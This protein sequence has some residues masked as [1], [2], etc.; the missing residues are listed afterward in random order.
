MTNLKTNT[1]LQRP[2]ILTMCADTVELEASVEELLT[3]DIF[4]GLVGQDANFVKNEDATRQ[5]NPQKMRRDISSKA[6]NVM[7]VLVKGDATTF[8]Q[9][10][11]R[12]YTLAV[13]D[14]ITLQFVC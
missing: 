13:E 2:S 14:I 3:L 8:D 7:T 10:F 1:V 4:L 5:T 11:A 9:A 6:S 12:K